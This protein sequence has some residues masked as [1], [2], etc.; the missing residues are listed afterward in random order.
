MALSMREDFLARLEDFCYDIPFLKKNRKGM[1]KLNGIQALSVIMDPVRGLVDRN[2]AIKILSRVVGF[3]CEDRQSWLETLSVD[4]SILSL[5]CSEIYQKA[6]Q[7]N[8][9]SI[10]EDLIEESGND[11]ID[12]FYDRN[13][14]KLSKKL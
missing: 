1:R 9:S 7:K 2:A 8:L 10:T 13:M 4:T 14:A 6:V 3:P 12:T 11:I 5:F